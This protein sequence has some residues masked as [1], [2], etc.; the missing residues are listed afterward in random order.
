MK[1]NLFLFFNF[2]TIFNILSIFNLVYSYLVCS[3]TKRM[4][5][6]YASKRK[7]AYFFSYAFNLLKK[8]L[9]I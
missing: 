9:N 1:K 6:V 7:F 2:K 4:I 3:Y 8:G 5:E